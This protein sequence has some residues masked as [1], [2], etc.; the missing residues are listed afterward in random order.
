M[1]LL[2]WEPSPSVVWMWQPHR[3]RRHALM[4]RTS[5]SPV[6][7][8]GLTRARDTVRMRHPP[9]WH[10]AWIPACPPL[11]PFDSRSLAVHQRHFGGLEVGTAGPSRG[12]PRAA[13]VTKESFF[14]RARS[15]P[16]ARTRV[17]PLVGQKLT[18][19][20]HLIARRHRRGQPHGMRWQKSLA[21]PLSA[22]P[23]G[24][25]PRQRN[26]PAQRGSPYRVTQFWIDVAQSASSPK[27]AATA[28]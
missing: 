27:T 2:F 23:H 22:S 7:E 26:R 8:L 19:R 5:S 3:R 4:G 25:P 18:T 6:A 15:R 24:R 10:P 12:D 21:V 28:D 1:K 20:P 11:I 14:S 9:S 16:H 13:R 17:R